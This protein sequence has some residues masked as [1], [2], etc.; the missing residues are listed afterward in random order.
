MSRF[1]LLKETAVDSYAQLNCRYILEHH[2]HRENHDDEIDAY[3][4]LLT[5]F[6][7]NLTGSQLVKFPAFY[8]TRRYITAFTSARHLSLPWARSL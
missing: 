5:P 2:H 1:E 7:E 4:W 6:L 3:G 8:G